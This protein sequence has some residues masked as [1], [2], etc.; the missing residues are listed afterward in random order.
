MAGI[1]SKAAGGLENKKKYNG[2]EF[3]NDLD[4]NTYEAYYRNL[5]PQTGRW[6]Q[7]DP[8][9]ENGMENVSPY[10]SMYDDPILK[11]DFLGNIPQDCHCC[12]GAA[13]IAAEGEQ[14]AAQALE[15][16]GEPAAAAVE[17]GTLVASAAVGI[18]EFFSENP[19]QHLAPPASPASPARPVPV[20]APAPAKISTPNVVQAQAKKGPKDLVGDA[21]I[22]KEKEAAATAR[23][24][25]R[26]V[27][28]ARG[29]SRTGNSNQV[30]RGDHNNGANRGDKHSKRIERAQREQK[31]ADAK[32]AAETKK[33][34]DTKTTE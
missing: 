10:T 18:W 33:A 19:V 7:I 15:A 22:Q 8:E 25:N 29:N 6:W 17:L 12:P 2:I 13:A 1:S 28:T 34:A 16:G 5:D 30:V 14:L 26:A 31:A 23:A 27:Q 3:D 24:E 4:L 20:A 11:S 21:K 9:I 32:K